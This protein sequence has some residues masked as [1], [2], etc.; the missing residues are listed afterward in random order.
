[1]PISFFRTQCNQGWAW[2]VQKFANSSQVR[3]VRTNEQVNTQFFKSLWTGELLFFKSSWTSEQVNTVLQK[4]MNKWTGEQVVLK[5]FVNSWTIEQFF[6]KESWTFEQVN[7]VFFLANF[8]TN[9][10]KLFRELLN[11][12]IIKLATAS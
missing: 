10:L 3:A 5:K 7:Y 4:F 6:S 12:T 11:R 9:E 2:T 8:W 1:M